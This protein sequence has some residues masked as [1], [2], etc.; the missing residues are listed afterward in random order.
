MYRGVGKFLLDFLSEYFPPPG[1]VSRPG[2]SLIA[3]SYA[4]ELMVSILQVINY[5]LFRLTK[6]RTRQ[7]SLIKFD[8][9]FHTLKSTSSLTKIRDWQRISCFIF[10]VSK[11]ETTF[12][13][14]CFETRFKKLFLWT[15]KQEKWETTQ[16]FRNEKL[17]KWNNF[18][19]KVYSLLIS[20]IVYFWFCWFLKDSFFAQPWLE[21]LES[22]K[23]NKSNWIL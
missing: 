22:P 11:R 8:D 14:F 1:K 17:E 9:F 6:H 7:S 13:R 5:R 2:L 10:R 23:S 4:V 20:G 3:S 21:L 12:S 15:L 18:F 16:L 19:Q